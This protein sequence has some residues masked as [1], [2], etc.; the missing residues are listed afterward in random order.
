M[1]FARAIAFVLDVE[2]GTVNDPQD[3]GGV[4]NGGIAQHWHQDMTPA[5]IAASHIAVGSA[6]AAVAPAA[7]I[8]KDAVLEWGQLAREVLPLFQILAALVAIGSGLLSMWLA[9]KLKEKRQ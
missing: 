9:W 4:T 7:P 6:V 3:P 8:V 1:S 2:G 5:Q